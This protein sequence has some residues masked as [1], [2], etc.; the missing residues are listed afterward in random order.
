MALLVSGEVDQYELK[1]KYGM[2]ATFE[3]CGLVTTNTPNCYTLL[4]LQPAG[5]NLPVFDWRV[6]IYNML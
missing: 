4:L 1:I 6:Y 3:C 2:I 5:A